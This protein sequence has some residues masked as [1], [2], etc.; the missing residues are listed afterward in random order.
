MKTIE[1]AAR[2]YADSI[3]GENYITECK[4]YHSDGFKSG[5]EFAQRWVPIEEELPEQGNNVLVKLLKPDYNSSIKD[6]TVESIT[7]AYVNCYNQFII[8]MMNNWESD[9]ITHWRPIELK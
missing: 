1:E 7:I 4:N 8:S 5:V 2:E 3:W 6:A 9:F